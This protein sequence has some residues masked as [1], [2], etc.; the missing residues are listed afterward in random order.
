MENPLTELGQA[1]PNG[2]VESFD[3]CQAGDVPPTAI[4]GKMLLHGIGGSQVVIATSAGGG[5]PLRT[6]AIAD[7][8]TCR[9]WQGVLLV[10]WSARNPDQVRY[11]LCQQI[12]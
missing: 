10:W 4:C 12:N 6:A 1:P 2:I 3:K 5:P 7:S 8:V 9:F 11:V